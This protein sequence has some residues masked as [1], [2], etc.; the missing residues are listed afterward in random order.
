MGD[1]TAA[2]TS[3]GRGARLAAAAGEIWERYRGQILD[4]VGV[5][6]KAAIA[7]L[8]G[9]LQPE[10]RREAEREA[11]RL[12]GSVGTTVVAAMLG[13]AAVVGLVLAATA[14]LALGQ[15][16]LDAEERT[17]TMWEGLFGRFRYR[18]LLRAALPRLFGF[19][20][21]VGLL[22][23][24]RIG[25]VMEAL[26]GDAR[27]ADARIPLHIGATDLLTGEKV[28]ITEGR[29]ADAVRASIS[30]PVLLRPWPVGGR[31]LIDGGASNPLPIDVA[32]REGCEVIIAMGFENAPHG[33]FGTISRVVSQ[34]TSITIDHLLRSTYAFYS[35]V[36]HAEIVPIMPDFGRHLSVTDSHLI[37]FIIEQGERAAEAELPYLLHLLNP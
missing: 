31:L 7:I 21:R 30:L 11:H 36:H 5:I 33:T 15:D 9:T 10:E 13:L 32:I 16:A 28:T 23:D 1:P 22:D 4:R 27:F 34:A 2:P 25:E 29:V 18:S 37:P 6:E 26:Y 20:E 24:S 17:H 19:S 8:E 14:A 3:D 12:A 35:A